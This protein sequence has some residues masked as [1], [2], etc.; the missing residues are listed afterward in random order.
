VKR[1]RKN[2]I[3]YL[4]NPDGT[5]STTQEQLMDTLI[6][7]FQNIFPTHNFLSTNAADGSPQQT[8]AGQDAM[9]FTHSVFD[10]SRTSHHSQKHEKQCL[11][12]S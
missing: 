1:T 12:R 8:H 4:Q 6:A 3:T 2:R 11:P 9:P 10:P 5:D 7:Y